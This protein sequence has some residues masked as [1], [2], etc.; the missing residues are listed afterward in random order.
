[1][2]SQVSFILDGIPEIIQ[3]RQ[4]DKMEEICKK[5]GKKADV[6]INDFYFLYAG[7]KVEFNL[8]YKQTINKDDLD[9]G[10]MTV[11]V[12]KNGC[13]ETKEKAKKKK[14]KYI[15]C[16]VCSEHCFLN[17]K[18]YKVKLSGC[19]NGHIT[20]NI[21]LNEYED[22]QYIDDSTIKCNECN[23]NKSETFQNQFFICITCKKNLCPLCKSKH[24]EKHKL[25][26][27]NKKFF[28]CS[29]HEDLYNSF[30]EKCKKNLC[31]LCEEDHI[32][33]DKIYYG[34]ILPNKDDIKKVLDNFKEKI[35]K[36]K[37]TI[38][39]IIKKIY[40]Y[41]LDLFYKV[42]YDILNNYDCHYRNYQVL[43]N[44]NRIKFNSLSKDFDILLN[45]NNIQNQW[46]ILMK[47][48]N[49]INNHCNFHTEKKEN[50]NDDKNKNLNLNGGKNQLDNMITI[51]YRA[52]NNEIKIF[53]KEFVQNNKDNC[54]IIY[55]QNNYELTQ[56]F[57]FDK[58]SKKDEIVQIKLKIINDL[59]NL[60]D[61]FY[62]C[63]S[64]ISLPDISILN[65]SKVEE[66]NG[67]FRGC[68]SLYEIDDISNWDTSNVKSMNGMFHSCKSLTSLPDISKWNIQN[69]K[70][71][72]WMFYNCKSIK[73]LSLISK[74][75][76]NED[77]NTDSMFDGCQKDVNSS[78]FN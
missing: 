6:N 62:G 63:K 2:E 77:I 19:K 43:Q 35:D 57:T 25:M 54:Y 56:N 78:S 70:D 29:E 10:T 11:L 51:K 58:N 65:T 52:N 72:S 38:D 27:Y 68:S 44:V 33:H 55:N 66:M 64:L 9:I 53:G 16:P 74:W 20:K 8:T 14:S 50:K 13:S 28:F 40:H 4:E 24:N 26:D 12:Y 3:C 67:M 47:I 30:C 45:D 46:L 48:Y 37:K 49:K 7:T 34:S 18:D 69:V 71:M 61:M 1:M 60:S 31:I 36:I 23:A 21:S 22:S 75:D 39:E 17:I 73:N 59:T 42:N 15:I 41:Y 76:I 5:F 32:D